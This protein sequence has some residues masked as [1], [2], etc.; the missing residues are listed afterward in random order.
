VMTQDKFDGRSKIDLNVVRVGLPDLS[1]YQHGIVV[2]LVLNV[3][4]WPRGRDTDE[5]N[6]A[7][8][9]NPYC[10]YYA[11]PDAPKKI[12]TAESFRGLYDRYGNKVTP[13]VPFPPGYFD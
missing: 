6:K 13:G 9:L 5:A 11:E 4:P 10:K 1:E 2:K 8:R 3:C 12:V 7:W